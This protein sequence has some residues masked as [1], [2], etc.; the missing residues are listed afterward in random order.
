MKNEDILRELIKAVKGEIIKDNDY[1]L[2][3]EEPLISSGLID[4]F[5]L[6][7][8]AILVENLFD[9]RIEDHELN[10]ETFD[11]LKQLAAIITLRQ[12]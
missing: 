5:S 2:T 12:S 6:V 3:D 7:D 10:S 4:S 1:P 9:V 8:L 11:S